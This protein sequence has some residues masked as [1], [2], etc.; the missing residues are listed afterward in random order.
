MEY[1]RMRLTSEE[2]YGHQVMSYDISPPSYV[3]KYT[4]AHKFYFFL[5]FLANRVPGSWGLE[6]TEICIYFSPA[7]PG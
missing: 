1:L 2:R 3:M 4:P 7:R 5:F 6:E